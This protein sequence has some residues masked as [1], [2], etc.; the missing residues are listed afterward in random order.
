MS[1]TRVEREQRRL[2]G[3][4]RRVVLLAAAAPSAAL[5]CSSGSG[6][7]NGSGA[8]AEV[9]TS[10][11]DATLLDDATDAAAE[12]PPFFL[13]DGDLPD[14]YVAWCEAGPPV[15]VDG[16]LCTYFERIPCGVP[17][18]T[19]VGP[20]GQLGPY[21]CLKMCTLDATLVACDLTD[22]SD[23]AGAAFI[24]C[25]LCTSGRRP[26]GLRR[27]RRPRACTAAGA[28]LARMAHLEAASVVAF[29][30]L[31]RDLARLRAPRALVRA[32][33]RSA[34]DEVRHARLAARLARRRGGVPIAPDAQEAGEPSLEAIARENAVEGCVRETFGAMLALW[35]ASRARD[36]DVAGAMRSIARDEARHAALAWAIARWAE[37]GLGLDARDAIRASQRQ[38]VRE[39][40]AEQAAAP[41]ADLARRLGLPTPQEALA[42]VDLAERALWLRNRPRGRRSAA[43]GGASQSR[44]R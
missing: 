20:N 19:V 38:A 13:G 27:A 8:D 36:A 39:L 42:L 6:D 30:R 5:A 16:N 1:R 40:R 35:Q 3:V 4:L 12:P 32:A 22:A 10:A 43:T 29:D 21:D 44:G 37:A 9:E 31:A 24:Q 14:L 26:A 17:Q 28:Y 18:G 15:A 11:V 2:A 25:D 7:T 23:D 33:Q 41:P 34:R